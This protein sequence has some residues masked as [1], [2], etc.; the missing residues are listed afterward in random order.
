MV[1]EISLERERAYNELLRLIIGGELG[2]AGTALSERKLAETLSTSR[3]PIREALRDL[4]RDGLIEIHPA[5]GTFLRR[6]DLD[7]VRDV[8][9]V[10]CA[11]EGTAAFLAA[12]RG[13]TPE[14]A[15]L[16]PVM[17]KLATKLD[18]RKTSDI[19][20]IG[21]AFHKEVLRASRN[22]VLIEAAEPLRIRCHLAFRLPRHFNADWIRDSVE[23]HLAILEAIEDQDAHRAQSL[24]WAHL[25]EGLEVRMEITRTLAMFKSPDSMQVD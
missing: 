2:D 13:M 16:A 9:E 1:E 12:M 10:R 22:Q 8:F 25:R 4:A 3:T 21:I 6:P 7:E 20:D 14:L 17:R 19:S 15:E 24:M 23:Q 11:L 18:Q 5:R